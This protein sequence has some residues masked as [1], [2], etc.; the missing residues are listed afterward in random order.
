MT[1]TTPSTPAGLTERDQETLRLAKDLA[2]SFR[3]DVTFTGRSRAE[4]ALIA[5]LS[6][7]PQ[8][9]ALGMFAGAMACSPKE[10]WDEAIARVKATR[11]EPSGAELRRAASDLVDAVSAKP[12]EASANRIFGSLKRL[13]DALAAT[14]SREPSGAERAGWKLVPIEPTEAMLN[15]S[16]LRHA[17]ARV[18]YGGMIARAPSREPEPAQPPA[19]DAGHPKLQAL[20]DSIEV[21]HGLAVWDYSAMYAL[22]DALAQ[23]EPRREPA[24]PAQAAEPTLCERVK[25]A[26]EAFE[27]GDDHGAATILRVALKATPPVSADKLPT[28]SERED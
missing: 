9:E 25:A 10:A 22:R 27:D 3:Y 1:H 16:Q 28:Q 19:P 20:I 18:V 21:F 26:L 5:H 14:H 7:A 17:D 15:G 12:A 8:R 23:A 6:A 11:P 4:Q 24:Q 13:R 2:E